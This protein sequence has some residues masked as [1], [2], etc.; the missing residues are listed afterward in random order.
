VRRAPAVL[1]REGAFGVVLLAPGAAEPQTLTGPGR[2]M[3]RALAQPVAPGDLAGELARNFDA[4][5]ARVAADIAP[6]LADLLRLGLIEE[7]G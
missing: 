6:V 2:E 7:V 1:W 3:W 5:P 4:D